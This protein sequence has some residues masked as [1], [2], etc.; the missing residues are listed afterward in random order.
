MSFVE[1]ALA[2]WER[3]WFAPVPLARLAAFRALVM[4]LVLV[5]LIAYAPAFREGHRLASSGNGAARWNPIFAFDVL[6]ILPGTPAQAEA[7][8]AVGLVA[9]TLAIVGLASRASCA[10]AGLAL[11][12]VAATV[13]SFEKVHHD[14]VALAF[15]LVALPFA[16]VGARGSV[17]AALRS[18]WRAWRGR[19]GPE[20]ARDEPDPAGL[21]GVPIR[22][23]QVSLAIGYG[24]AGL[25]KLAIAG[26][27]WVNG[28]TLMAITSEFDGPWTP[29]LAGDVTRMAA[30]SAFALATQ[31]AFP[32]A[33]F[34]RRA[35]W[36]LVPAVVATHVVNWKTLDTGPYATLWF[37]GIAFVALERVPA[38][39]RESLASPSPSRRALGVVVPLA[40]TALVA[41]LWFGH[42][43]PAWTLV[44]W[45]PIAATLA[46]AWKR[47][48]ALV[49]RYAAS[50]A[51]SRVAASVVDALDWS[52]RVGLAPRA[53]GRSGLSSLA[54]ER[55]GRVQRGFR[56]WIALA[57]ELPLTAPLARVWPARDG[58]R[59]EP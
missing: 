20:R 22:V 58:E 18:A 26:P 9:A 10:V 50:C 54:V 44:V 12:Y 38:W 21:A 31:L 1:R 35:V 3:F 19:S 5:D 25:S 6:G 34:S 32:L 49:L 55:A 57:R 53:D 7:V 47:D 17:D 11:L 42:Y 37:L 29:W 33:L 41:W 59:D 14:K 8:V 48:G 23:T 43:L 27:E 40:P 52:G 56:A 4:A 13:Y 16:P 24:C 46:L 30:F 45:I 51:P 15:T 36:I 28:Y 39:M 2:S